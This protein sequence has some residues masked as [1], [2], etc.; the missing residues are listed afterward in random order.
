MNYL[1][2]GHENSRD[3]E[4]HYHD[5]GQ[6]NPAV[7][8]HGYP[9]CASAW[10]KQIPLLVEMGHRVIAYDRRGF[11]ESSKP[12]GG[13]NFDIFAD[14][15]NQVIEKLELRDITLIGHSMGSGEIVRYLSRYGAE[16]VEKAVLIAPLQ[17]FLLKT[18]DNPDGLKQELFDGFQKAAKEDRF[19]FLTQFFNQFFSSGIVGNNGVSHE[20]LMHQ[21]MI[22]GH[23]SAQAI[24]DC[25]AS[26][27][28]DFRMD[29]SKVSV[30]TLIIQGTKDKV[31]PLEITGQKLV[32]LL[33][34]AKLATIDGAPHGLLWTHAKE[35][36]RELSQFLIDVKE[37]IRN[38]A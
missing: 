20:A 14:D 18:E 19:A 28:T 5:F 10:E 8:I 4:L 15:L 27:I 31:L 7:L 12:Y 17:P 24:H 13:Y 9:Q 38:S 23:A 29:L 11:G 21:K 34:N 33:P 36:N 1:K 16:R 37:L 32:D 6:G 2:V 3:I 35:V 26:W 22:G 30:P 25:I